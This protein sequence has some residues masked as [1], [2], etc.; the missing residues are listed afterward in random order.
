MASIIG[1]ETLQHT[2]GTTAATIDSSGRILQPAKP[3][4][5]LQGNNSNNKSV[6]DGEV[7]G[8]TDDGQA[9]FKT[10]GDG[11]FL[12][13][14]ITYN[15]ATGEITVPVAGV[16]YL[17]GMFYMN[18]S[19]IAQVTIRQNGAIRARNYDG[20]SAVGSMELSIVL[21]LNANDKI[22]YQQDSGATRTFYEGAQHT[23][24]FGALLG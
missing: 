1:V 5:N 15:S 16:Y 7:F 19:S 3:A 18:Q 20:S 9:A 13:G 2:N 12:Q 21:N 11:A 22:T 10:S 17:C 8:A 6:G 14:G 4:F 24:V 23:Y